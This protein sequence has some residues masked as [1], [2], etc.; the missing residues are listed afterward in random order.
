MEQWEHERNVRAD[1]EQAVRRGKRHG[2]RGVKDEVLGDVD[3]K[4]RLS[5]SERW[6]LWE[7]QRLC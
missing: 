3:G 1:P 6:T 4:D 7:G 2:K 5:F